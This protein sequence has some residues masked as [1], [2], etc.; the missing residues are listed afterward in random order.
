[1]TE[2]H[3]KIN[4]LLKAQSNKSLQNYC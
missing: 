1:M 3:V 4:K 2:R